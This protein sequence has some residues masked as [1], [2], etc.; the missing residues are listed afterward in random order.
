MLRSVLGYVA[1]ILTLMVGLNLIY[2]ALGFGISSIAFKMVLSNVGFGLAAI[3]S[4][5]T[6]MRLAARS[7]ER[8]KL[9]EQEQRDRA[10]RRAAFGNGHGGA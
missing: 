4:G 8:L 6:T 1:G 3:V 2:A 5:F 7:S 10:V 9:E